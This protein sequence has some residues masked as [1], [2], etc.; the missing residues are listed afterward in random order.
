MMNTHMQPRVRTLSEAV[1]WLEQET[2]TAD[3]RWRVGNGEWQTMK[4]ETRWLDPA[5]TARRVWRGVVRNEWHRHPVGTH[6]NVHVE[7][8]GRFTDVHGAMP[9]SLQELD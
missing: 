2:Q 1:A 4:V 5:V 7:L 9:E 8:A 6:V 3:V